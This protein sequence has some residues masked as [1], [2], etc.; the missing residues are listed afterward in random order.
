M[1]VIMSEMFRKEIKSFMGEIPQ[2]RW[3]M[4]FGKKEEK[5]SELPKEVE[6]FKRW[7]D[8]EIETL[9]QVNVLPAATSCTLKN[10]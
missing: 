6:E 3:D 4:A 2:D 8:H 5:V 9:G 7:W 10:D 1:E